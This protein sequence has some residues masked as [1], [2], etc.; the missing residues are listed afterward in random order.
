M[1]RE[2]EEITKVVS[3]CCWKYIRKKKEAWA[4]KIRNEKIIFQVSQPT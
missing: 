3:P 2:E 4:K 1:T